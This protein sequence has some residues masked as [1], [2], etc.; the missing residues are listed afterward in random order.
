MLAT[1]LAVALPTFDLSF[2]MEQRVRHGELST[3]T[4]E[5]FSQAVNN[6]RQFLADCKA[7]PLDYDKNKYGPGWNVDGSRNQTGLD[8]DEIWH[9]HILNTTRYIA[10]CEEY[11][12][13]YLHHTPMC[14]GG[15]D[16]TMRM[17]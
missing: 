7:Q 10:D 3:W 1:M 17:Q 12:G 16:G 2:I 15:G 11:F 13:Y 14:D 5:R 9:T 6:Y 4:P 8:V